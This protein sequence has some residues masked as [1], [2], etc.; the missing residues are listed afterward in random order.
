MERLKLTVMFDNQENIAIAKISKIYGTNG[1]IVV[2][3]YDNFPDEPNL[4]E[5]FF[6]KLGGII[7]PLF[8][9]KFTRQGNTKAVMIFDDFN[10]EYRVNELIGVELLTL[11]DDSD[12]EEEEDGEEEIMFKDLVGYTL[13]DRV[14]GKSGII[15]GYIDSPDNPIFEVDMRG[16][17]ILVP[18]TDDIIELIDEDAEYVDMNLPEGLLDLYTS[19]DNYDI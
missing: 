15:T 8:V 10:T 3:L 19:P 11:N 5:P 12:E 4:N 7:V 14:S 9:Q 16:L 13:R 17:E 18:A 1:E 6:A 2:R